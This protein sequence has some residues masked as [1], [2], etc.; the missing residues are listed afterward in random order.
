MGQVKFSFEVLYHA[1]K[2]SQ[3]Y[4]SN[5]MVTKLDVCKFEKAAPFLTIWLASK[6]EIFNAVIAIFQL[7][8][9]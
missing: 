5:M 7:L 9:L 3:S 8:L 1:A 2:R 6:D 4:I